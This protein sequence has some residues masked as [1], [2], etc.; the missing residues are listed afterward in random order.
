MSDRT[1]TLT[2]PGPQGVPGAAWSAGAGAP[3]PDAARIGDWYIDTDTLDYWT[4]TG[5]A[6]WTI[7]GNFGDPV[8]SGQVRVLHVA[9]GTLFELTLGGTIENPFPVWT[10]A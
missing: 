5:D 6:Q 4:K 1:I 10:P 3:D 9:S 8:S 7:K 2:R